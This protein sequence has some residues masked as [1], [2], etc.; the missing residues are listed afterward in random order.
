MLTFICQAVADAISG[1]GC[2]IT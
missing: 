1:K 2:S